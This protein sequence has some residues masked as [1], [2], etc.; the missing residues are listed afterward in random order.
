MYAWI[1]G[2]IIRIRRIG[3]TTVYT[4]NWRTLLDAPG[5]DF[6]ALAIDSDEESNNGRFYMMIYDTNSH[7]IRIGA[8]VMARTGEALQ[9]ISPGT[10]VNI[11]LIALNDALPL[12]KFQQRTTGYNTADR[13]GAIDISISRGV[14]WIYMTSLFPNPMYTS[15]PRLSFIIGYDFSFNGAQLVLERNTNLDSE[16]LPSNSGIT[17]E[18]IKHENVDVIEDAYTH[19]GTRNIWHYRDPNQLIVRW[20]NITEKPPDATI[21]LRWSWEPKAA[22]GS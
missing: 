12:D 1:D 9:V 13:D 11:P 2:D 4:A 22:S 19:S 8:M 21:E 10:H 16:L 20:P 14:L 5:S 7:V 15:G 3:E 18:I 6:I 17:V